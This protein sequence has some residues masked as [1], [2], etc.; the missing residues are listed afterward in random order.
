MMIM[1]MKEREK[2]L[3]KADL[4]TRYLKNGSKLTLYLGEESSSMVSVYAEYKAYRISVGKPYLSFPKFI[5]RL[6]VSNTKSVEEL[7]NE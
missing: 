7:I 1:T 3:V 2:D 4:V 6:A 5:M